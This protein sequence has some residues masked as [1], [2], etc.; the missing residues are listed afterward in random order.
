LQEGITGLILDLRG[1]PG[2]FMSAAAYV[3]GLFL[4][5]GELILATKSRRDMDNYFVRTVEDGPLID[6]PL[7]ILVNRGSASASEIVAGAL[8][9]H[10]R[11]VVVGDTTFGK[12]LVQTNIMLDGGNALRVTTSKYYLPSGRLVQRFADAD[13][14]EHMEIS[15][16]ELNMAYRTDGGRSVYGGGGV[17]P[18]LRVDPDSITLLATVLSYGNYFF[19]F[20]VDYRAEYG[21]I[22]DV[23][24]DEIV[25]LFR[26]YV[27]ERGFEYPNILEA[28][29]ELLSDELADIGSSEADEIIE[30]MR[31]KA[32]RMEQSAWRNSESYIKR[33]LL[34]R[35]A[36]VRGGVE[37]VYISSRIVNDRQIRAA[38]EVL[39][40]KD[41]YREFLEAD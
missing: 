33:A 20:A 15:R 23:I 1:N 21:S 40:N 26:E 10:D 17:A 16:S 39:K 12:G 18:D 2:G 34:S 4:P 30:R 19:K 36:R 8:Q 11:A 3:A 37:E 9:D 31:M 35:F 14:A 7:V 5:K 41:V 27:Y 38:I 25:K 24:S 32:S 13:W 29:V 22:P 28:H 6:I